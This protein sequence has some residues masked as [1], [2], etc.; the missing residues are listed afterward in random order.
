MSA[1]A[2]IGRRIARG[3][4]GAMAVVAL[5]WG[6]WVGYDAVVT[7]PI[8]RVVFAGELDRL[9]QAIRTAPPASL[10][11]IRASARRVPW[12]RDAA[13]RR[14]FP[15]TVEITFDA[16]EALARWNEAFLVSRAGEVFVAPDA[17]ELPRLR[18]PE[19]KAR[20]VV[21]EYLAAAAVFAPL[22]APIVEFRLSP[23]GAWHATLASGLAI[24]L[25]RGDWRPRAERF[26]AA[27][28]RLAPE[29]RGTVYADLRYSGGFALK[30]AATLTLT[31]PS[32][33]R[34][35]KP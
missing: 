7:Q 8:E 5:A 6:A 19:G 4:A 14:A 27:W 35:N 33:G 24:A 29:A 20:E 26:V 10:E 3:L 15:A 22:G 23:R 16:Y 21:A 32:Q 34:G 9:A 31:A 28:P 25:G 1:P 30:R 12:V 17:A 2:P 13:V 11:A 18:G